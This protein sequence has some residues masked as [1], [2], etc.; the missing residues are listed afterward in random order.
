MKLPYYILVFPG[1]GSKLPRIKRTNR[2][3]YMDMCS[4]E[5]IIIHTCDNDMM[6]IRNLFTEIDFQNILSVLGLSL[7]RVFEDYK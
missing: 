4:A 1:L 6:V 3:K 2:P 5:V 7:D